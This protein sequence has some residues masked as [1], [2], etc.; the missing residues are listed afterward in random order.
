MTLGSAAVI[1]V[2]S[3][4]YMRT[5]EAAAEWDTDPLLLPPPAGAEQAIE[6]PIYRKSDVGSSP[7][8]ASGVETTTAA[9]RRADTSADAAKA[10]RDSA[11]VP[12]AAVTI[13]APV[14]AD[15]SKKPVAAPPPLRDSVVPTTAAAVVEPPVD[16]L[17]DPI[18]P[19][20]DGKFP[21]YG[22]SRHGD[23]G[24][25]VVVTNGKISNLAISICATEYGCEVLDGLPERF[26][27]R[28]R[29]V[30]DRVSGA[31][32]SA[33]AYYKAVNE[34]MARARK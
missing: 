12:T 29:V 1:A 23:I 15:S 32:H 17:P 11:K 4:G 24:V 8:G 22:T 10:T 5:R 18:F 30:I 19:L 7:A 14:P 2:Y 16:T 25:D 21:G 27:M 13:A 31:T 33:S 9:P 34:A 28:Q 6:P 20:K 3:A 26:L